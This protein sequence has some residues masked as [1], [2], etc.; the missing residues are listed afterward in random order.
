MI[1]IYAVSSTAELRCDEVDRFAEVKQQ[2]L[3]GSD[4]SHP[5]TRWE[6]SHASCAPW[7]C[8]IAGPCSDDGGGPEQSHPWEELRPARRRSCRRRLT[9]AGWGS[10]CSI[11][12]RSQLLRA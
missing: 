8:G 7:G 11:A 9:T 6:N 12:C 10:P 4:A 2:T 5:G 3:D 1:E